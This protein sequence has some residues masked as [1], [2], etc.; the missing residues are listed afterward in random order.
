MPR[1]SPDEAVVTAIVTTLLSS[2]GVTGTDV[3]TRIYNDVPQT[4]LF[5]YVHVTLPSG[6]RTDTLG[7]LG[8]TS[9]VDVKVLSQYQGDREGMRIQDQ[10]IQTL[11]QTRP[12]VTGHVSL[13]LAFDEQTRYSEVINGITTRHHVATFRYWTEQSSS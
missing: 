7:R 2:T 6:N 11:D 8:R 10:C 12:T 1:R 9:L 3:G 13:G 5:P 4:T